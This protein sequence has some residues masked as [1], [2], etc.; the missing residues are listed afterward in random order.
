MSDIQKNVQVVQGQDIEIVVDLID[1]NSCDGNQPFSLAGLTGCT[2]YFPASVASTLPYVAA[3]GVLD[4][5][6]LG[7]VHFSLS[8][9]DTGNLNVGTDQNIEIVVDQGPKR[10]IAQILNKLDVSG[11]LF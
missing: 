10:S 3:S 2:G 4:S 6:D 1:A 8:E 5:A 7:K 11:R 9:T